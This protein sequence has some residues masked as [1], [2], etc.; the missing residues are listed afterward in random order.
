MRGTAKQQALTANVPS[1]DCLR[2]RAL[3]ER[4]RLK[5]R[6]G[7]CV[8]AELDRALFRWNI[9]LREE[10]SNKARVFVPG[11]NHSI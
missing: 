4:M 3:N 11:P 9:H 2:V 5:L 6:H 8:Q 10:K 1:H 7:N